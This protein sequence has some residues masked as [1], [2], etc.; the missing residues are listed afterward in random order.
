MSNDPLIDVLQAT[1]DVFERADKLG[2]EDDL[3]KLRDEGGI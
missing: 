1:V 3:T 2:I